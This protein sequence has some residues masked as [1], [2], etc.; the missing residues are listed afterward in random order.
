[1]LRALHNRLKAPIA[2][3]LLLA[4]INIW[5]TP[6]LAQSLL[7]MPVEGAY[8]GILENNRVADIVEEQSQ[9]YNF[10]ESIIYGVFSDENI[11]SANVVIGV[12]AIVY[13][14]VIGT[15]FI[16]SEG[17][18]EEIQTAQKHFG[19]VILGLLVIS[20]AQIAGFTLLNPAQNV[21][22]DFF[23]NNNIQEVFYAKA[24]QIKLFIQI[25]IG[26]IAL[27]SII[28]SAFRIMSSTGNEEVIG[29]EKQ[30][31]QNFLFATVLILA[32]EVIVTGVFYM[33]G[34]NREGATNQAVSIGIEQIMG[35]ITALLSII[36]AAALIMVILASL[37]YV[38][39]LGDE[40]RAGRAK[41][42]LVAN[43]IAIVIIF[44]AYTILRF[45]F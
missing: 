16:L 42:L 15:R 2:A 6:V 8:G 19:F 13:L 36:A 29:K 17:K 7:P 14:V 33:P 3:L 32:A 1:M 30:L 31:L 44:S 38:I 35:L 39:S 28:T 26:G 22:P 27:L 4:V 37:Y 11:K 24:M 9:S 21:N 23:V 18:E 43:V 41:K 20:V 40:E 12:V 34:A 10:F 45:F 5:V 25:L